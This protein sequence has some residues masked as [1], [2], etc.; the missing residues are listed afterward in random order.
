MSTD[1]LP[2]QF[3]SHEV[4]ALTINGEPW[5]V[6][7]D[8]ANV[9]EI[10]EVSRLASRISDDLR[11]THPIPDRMGRTQN[12]T[13][14]NEAGMYEVVLR[15][16][17]PE[18]VAFRRWLT[19]E[20]LPA[21]R[22]HGGYLTPEKVEEALLNPDTII[23]LATELKTERAKRAELELQARADKPKVI[24]ADAVA[25]SQG[26][27]L[28]GELA[29][30]MRGNGI[31]IGQQRLF[32]WMREN[33]YLIRRKGS[34]WNMPTQYAMERG[35]FEIKET[36]ITHSDGHVTISKTPKVTGKGQQFFINL[37]L[38]KEAA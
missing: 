20:V 5:F 28:V 24:F 14:V 32:Q 13:I 19:T 2:F 1:I 17:K 22:K 34:D 23:K 15:S 6:L 12:T 30:I 10:R 35:L 8:L 18:A 21:I 33:G 29:K 26:T 9:L 27:I 3:E 36:A 4:R 31:E 16:D 38:S 25:A 7:G 11:Q 37:F